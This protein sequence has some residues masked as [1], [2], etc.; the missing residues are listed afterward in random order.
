M[1]SEWTA[2]ELIAFEDKVKEEF[3]AGRVNGPVHLA[4]G[5]E[6]QLIEIF[7]DISPEDWIFSTYRST[8]HA[9][10]HGVA[11]DRVMREIVAGRSLSLNFP[12]HRFFTSAI[13]GGCLPI[14][15]GVAAGIKCRGWSEKVWVFVG[16][17]AAS[18]GMHHDCVVYADI[19]ELPITFVIED[20][21]YSTNTPSADAWGCRSGCRSPKTMSDRTIHYRYERT[22]PHYGSGRRRYL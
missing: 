18:G 2:E 21:G 16:D 19:N 12:D 15:V 9:L 10:L 8:Y 13:V 6:L 3:D 17:M 4:G 5:N 1:R 7:K 20:N 22:H 11:P 14:S